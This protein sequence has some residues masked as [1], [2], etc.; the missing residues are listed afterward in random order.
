MSFSFDWSSAIV[1]PPTSSQLRLDAA[2]PY[3]GATLLWVR[4]QTRDGL[5]VFLALMRTPVGSTIYLQDRNDH[6]ASVTLATTGIANGLEGYV[7]IPVTWVAN[8]LDPLNNNQATELVTIA[9]AP[10]TPPPS[11]GSGDALAFVTLDEAAAHLHEVLAGMPDDIRADL[12]L[13]IGI[14]S[15]V[16]LDY[17][18]DRGD[19]TWDAFT[20]PLVVKGAT[21]AYLAYEWEHR[22]D[23]ETGATNFDA[24]IWGVLDRVL[25]RRRD[26][27]LQ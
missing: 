7:E 25:K 11:G 21:L 3:T 20:V 10:T 1:P 13:K 16:V 24:S 26:P 5:D 18:K 8:G 9:P 27:A 4:N 17:L 6:N 15:S 14:A 23:D 22:G 19:P 2:F 12:E